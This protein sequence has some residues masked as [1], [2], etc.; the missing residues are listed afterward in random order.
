MKPEDSPFQFSEP[1]FALGIVTPARMA[2]LM[3][4]WERGED[5]HPEHYR[6]RAFQE[7]LSER[8]PLPPDTALA[9]Y[10]LGQSDPDRAMGESIM[11]EI[12]RLPECP[13]SVVAAAANSGVRHLVRAAAKH[14]S[15]KS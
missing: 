7:F 5:P 11:H 12:V 10:A 13:D 6:W 15:T 1:W 4:E 9:L 3:L 8:R 2:T 14:E